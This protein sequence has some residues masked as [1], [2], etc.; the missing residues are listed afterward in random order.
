MCEVKKTY[1]W[2][3]KIKR[4]KGQIK[5]KLRLILL[6][7]GGKVYNHGAGLGEVTLNGWS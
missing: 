3:Q 7:I 5:V 4:E 6:V 1:L 2:L